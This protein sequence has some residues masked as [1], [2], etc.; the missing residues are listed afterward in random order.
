MRSILTVLFIIWFVIGAVAAGQ[1]HYFS[2]EPK[3]CAHAGTIAVTILAGPL[4]YM[5]ANPKI[6]CTIP[7]PSK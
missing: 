6:S 5:G 2:G 7:P 3:T 4:N 1:R